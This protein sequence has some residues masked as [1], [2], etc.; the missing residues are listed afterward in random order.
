MRPS[1]FANL[2]SLEKA[3]Q[4]R[5]RLGNRW[6]KPIVV[7]NGCFDL[8][9]RGH[10]AG[11]ER[12]RELGVALFVLINSDA[13]VR[14]L[15]GETRPIVPESD[16]AAMVAA[17]RCVDGVVLFEGE[18]CGEELAALHPDV[19]AKSAEYR[20]CQHAAEAAALELVGATTVWL[21]RRGDWSTTT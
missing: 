4:Y 16:R 3:V 6:R 17:L 1:K 21:Q 11:L 5:E 2:M 12:A 13:S 14:A 7:T 10:I 9:H 8:L 19:Y 18:H 20:D 15:K